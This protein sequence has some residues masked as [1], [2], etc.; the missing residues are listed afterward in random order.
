MTKIFTRAALEEFTEEVNSEIS[1]VSPEQV[2]EDTLTTDQAIQSESGDIDSDVVALVEAAQGLE[3]ILSLVEQAPGEPDQPLDAFSE[4]AVNV[5]LESND[6]VDGESNPLKAG[7]SKNQVLAKVKDFA[8]KVW[9]MLRE[10][11]KKIA[12]WIRATWARYTDVLVKN[13]EAAKRVLQ[14]AETLTPNSSAEI[15]DKGILAKVA[16]TGNTSIADALSNSGQFAIAQAHKGAKELTLAARD[17]IDGVFAGTDENKGID[18]F[19]DALQTSGAAYT[20]TASAEQIAAAKAPAGSSVTVTAPFFGGARGFFATP[21]DAANI[22]S[23][24]HG[25]AVLDSVKPAES[26]TAPSAEEIKKIAN[27]VISLGS[28]VAVY[29]KELDN[30]DTLNKELDK[31]ASKTVAEGVDEKQ[32][33]QLQAIIPKVIKGPQVDAYAYAAKASAI[34]IAYANAAIAAHQAA[35]APAAKEA[36]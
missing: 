8:K 33:R 30:L 2:L 19:F 14:A 32:L 6:L 28:L 26:V 11:G 24:K 1:A 9:E 5:A 34:G 12:E 25:I 4:K 23:W 20:E 18:K 10:F 16:T 7:D 17:A 21:T 29:Q 35:N 22:Q 13:G 36:A 3:D 27:Q 31:A 15:T